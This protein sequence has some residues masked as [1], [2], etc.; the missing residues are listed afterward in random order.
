MIK[1]TLYHRTI[2]ILVQAYFNDTLEHGNCCACAVGNIISANMGKKYVKSTRTTHVNL[3]E[4][5]NGSYYGSHWRSWFSDIRST[6]GMEQIISTGYSLD[7]V[8]KIE[9]AFER[10]DKGHSSDEWMFNGLMS[11]IDVLDEIHENKDA[12]VTTVSK[13]K[14]QKC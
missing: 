4:E 14:F 6:I 12:S 10:A 2:D 13:N 8:F 9:M 1:E 11:V 5:C 7:E 3:W